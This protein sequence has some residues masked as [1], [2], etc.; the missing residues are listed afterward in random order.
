MFNDLVSFH[1]LFIP[2]WASLMVP[3]TDQH[4]ESEK[5]INLDDIAKRAICKAKE[6]I[7][8]AT[9]FAYQDVNRNITFSIENF[10]QWIVLYGTSNSLWKAGNSLIFLVVDLTQFLFVHLYTSTS[11]DS[12]NVPL[13]LIQIYSIFQGKLCS[14]RCLV[15]YNFFGQVLA[16]LNAISFKSKT[17][18]ARGTLDNPETVDREDSN[19]LWNFTMCPVYHE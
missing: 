2:N 7:S 19:R 15:S 9:I 6:T 1:W 12:W 5:S 16:S 17:P 3:L 14:G 11:L 10:H 4:H 8:K 13:S 18:S